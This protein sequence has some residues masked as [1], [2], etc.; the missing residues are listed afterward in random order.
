MQ[1]ETPAGAVGRAGEEMGDA[2]GRVVGAARGLAE[3]TSALTAE[4]RALA[5][6]KTE[7][8][9]S[10]VRERPLASVLIAFGVGYFLGR[11]ARR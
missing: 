8:M 11:I 9:V 2:A 4:A 7:E 5:E 10:W 6:Q 3:R 1:K